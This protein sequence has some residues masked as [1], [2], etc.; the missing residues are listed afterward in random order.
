LLDAHLRERHGKDIMTPRREAV[1]ED[2]SAFEY[3]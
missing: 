3:A 2:L 1:F